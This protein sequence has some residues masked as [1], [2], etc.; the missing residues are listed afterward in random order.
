VKQLW[1]KITHWELWPFNLIYAPLG[2][3]WLYYAFK[4]RAIWFFTPTNP[5]LE[6]AGF[7][8]ESKKEMYEQ[9]PQEYYP[10]TLFVNAKANFDGLKENL[11]AAGFTYPFIAKPAIGMQGMMFRKLDNEA[12][13]KMYHDHIPVEYLIQDL[14]DMPMEFSVFHI[15][16]PGQTKGKVTGFILKEYL[17]VDG[18]GKHT[19][20]ELIQQHPRA[21]H[22]EDEMRHKHAEHLDYVVPAGQKYILS[23]AGN[24]NRG[25]RFINLH[26]QIDQ[27]LCDVFDKISNAAGQFYYGRYDLKCTSIEDLK[28]GKNISILEY[29]GAGA[30]PN[31]IYDCGMSYF[32][33]LKEIIMHWED[34]YQIGKIN[35]QNGVPYWSYIR[36]QRHFNKARRFFKVL[37]QYDLDLLTN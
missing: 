20:I 29:N 21:Q 35:H 28:A 25:A 33:A 4:A 27:Q 8:G 36:G 32:R 15:R 17:H 19:L 13:L 2:F 12:Q 5:T 18:D 26:K 30:E 10:K 1:Q 11:N 16:Y 7:E 6:F 23:I 37:R 14:V 31:H 24:H 22:R 3:V 9:L 34:M